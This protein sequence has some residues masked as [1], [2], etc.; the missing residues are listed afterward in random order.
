[1]KKAILIIA[2]VMVF[3]G[4][5]F[6]ISGGPG[7][8]IYWSRADTETGAIGDYKIYKLEIDEAFQPVGGATNGTVIA[9]VPFIDNNTYNFGKEFRYHGL[10]VFDPRDQGGLGRLTLPSI[11]NHTPVNDA[12][13][14]GADR[15]YQPWDIV[16]VNPSDASQTLL[17]DGRN[18]ASSTKWNTAAAERVLRAPDN[19]VP[20]TASNGLAFLVVDYMAGYPNYQQMFYV[21]DANAN[22]K[23]DDAESEG[24]YVH[25]PGGGIQPMDLEFCDDASLYYTRYLYHQADKIVRLWIGDGGV[26]H[27]NVYYSAGRD[28]YGYNVHDVKN[29]V[30]SASY[31]YGLAVGPS[32]SGLVYFF[33][34]DNTLNP[35]TQLYV[36]R[37]AIFALHDGDG[38]NVVAYTNPLDDV[39]KIWRDTDFGINVDDIYGGHDLEL[40]VNPDNGAMTLFASGYNKKLFALELAD[41]GLAALGVQLILSSGGPSQGYFAQGF[42]IDMNPG[43][44][45]PEPATLLLFGTGALGVLGHIRRQRMK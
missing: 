7:G 15:R 10:E 32:A 3:G 8:Y 23:I 36:Q 28:A 39:V 37:P 30:W 43:A 29:P 16:Q 45:I 19:W 27:T 14:W 35:D 31:G 4:S 42:E 6:A 5:A 18:Y 1:M 38:D 44:A 34:M 21:Y 9:T 12:G 2:L 33:G 40:Y 20:G 17:C 13:S 26:T 24:T 25:S 41:N 22:G 11:A